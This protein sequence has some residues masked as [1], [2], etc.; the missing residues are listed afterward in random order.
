MEVLLQFRKAAAFLSSTPLAHAQVRGNGAV[1][2]GSATHHLAYSRFHKRTQRQPRFVFFSTGSVLIARASVIA[3]PNNVLVRE[4]CGLKC[5]PVYQVRVYSLRCAAVAFP[6]PPRTHAKPA[7]RVS[8][9]SRAGRAS[10]RHGRE[11]RRPPAPPPKQP[12]TPHRPTLHSAW[13]VSCVSGGRN[14][15]RRALF[16]ASSFEGRPRGSGG[17]PRPDGIPG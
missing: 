6:G 11:G 8:W 2:C 10:R 12:A 5:A 17:A 16:G 15:P 14:A 9:P 3:V 1:R 7:P 4:R 13:S